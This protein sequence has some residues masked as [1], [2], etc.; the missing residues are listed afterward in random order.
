[1][2]GGGGG[3]GEHIYIYMYI[4][5]SC[6]RRGLGFKGLRLCKDICLYMYLRTQGLGLDRVMKGFI[7]IYIYICTYIYRYIYM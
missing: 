1:M 7:H 2:G 5:L 6:M 4:S 3:G